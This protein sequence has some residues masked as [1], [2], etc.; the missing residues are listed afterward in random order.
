MNKT[1]YGCSNKILFLKN[2]RS[3]GSL[4][5]IKLCRS[6]LQVR[7]TLKIRIIFEISSAS[8]LFLGMALVTPPRKLF[9]NLI[10]Q[11]NHWEGQKRGRCW[12]IFIFDFWLF[13]RYH[14]NSDQI[15]VKIRLDKM[16]GWKWLY[17]YHYC[18]PLKKKSANTDCYTLFQLIKYFKILACCVF[19]WVEN[20]SGILFHEN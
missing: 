19:L 9:R 6:S 7:T 17:L 2:W 8:C 14:G 10:K 15:N 4:A 13:L 1:E 16:R 5:K 18:L 12:S 11:Q 20:S 3:K